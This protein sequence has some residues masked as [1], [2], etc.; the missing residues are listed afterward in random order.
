MTTASSRRPLKPEPPSSD[1]NGVTSTPSP[2]LKP[3]DAAAHLG[4]A[5][6][7][8]RNWTSMRFVPHVKRR[9]IVRYHRDE[10]D[11]WLAQTLR[12]GRSTKA[13]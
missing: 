3:A 9:G 4:I 7:T 12:P 5:L 10:L 8:L 6:G 11:R 2:W 13:N 1:A